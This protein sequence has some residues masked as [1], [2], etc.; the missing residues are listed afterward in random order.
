MTYHYRF[1]QIRSYHEIEIEIYILSSK[2]KT[3]TYLSDK[4]PEEQQCD[5]PC[6]EEK[7]GTDPQLVEQ[8][9]VQQSSYAVKSV[10]RAGG[11]KHKQA[12]MFLQGSTQH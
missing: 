5:V 7:G 4:N 2:E 11:G 10:G 8:G 1:Y 12:C 6:K 9:E 3:K